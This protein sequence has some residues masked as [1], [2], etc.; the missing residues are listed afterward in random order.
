MNIDKQEL[1]ELK[2]KVSNELRGIDILSFGLKNTDER[3]NI[4]A[5]SVICNPEAH[6]LYEQLALKRFFDF[7]HKYEFRPTPVKNSSHFMKN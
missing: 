3:L 2:I 7:L 4:Y 1:R 5:F 6:N